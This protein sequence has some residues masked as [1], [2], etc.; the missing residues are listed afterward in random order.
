MK[1][2]NRYAL[3]AALAIA[4]LGMSAVPGHDSAPRAT[5]QAPRR[6]LKRHREEMRGMFGLTSQRRKG[7]GWTYRHV[8]RMAAKARNC[9]RNKLAH[10][11]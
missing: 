4:G 1:S 7:P 2:S 6:D 3:M 5:V 11:R 8:K 10:R 9:R